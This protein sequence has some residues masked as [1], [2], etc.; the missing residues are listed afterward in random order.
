MFP[1]SRRAPFAA[2]RRH[3][4]LRQ[5]ALIEPMIPHRAAKAAGRRFGRAVHV[6]AQ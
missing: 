5:S 4:T 1:F 2:A 6:L 3:G